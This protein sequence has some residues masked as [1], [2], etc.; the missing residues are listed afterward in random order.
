MEEESSD[1]EPDF[2]FRISDD[3]KLLQKEREQLSKKNLE[4]L[5]VQFVKH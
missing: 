5:V 4:T 2:R 1:E 3:K